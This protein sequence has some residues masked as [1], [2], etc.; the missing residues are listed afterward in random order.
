MLN[1]RNIP[2][3]LFPWRTGSSQS[4]GLCE[5]LLARSR[6]CRH[7]DP[8]QMLLLAERA[9]AVALELDP[10][11]YG[12]ELVADMRARSLAELSNA[13]RVADDLEAAERAM[14]RAVEWSSQGT[15]DPLLL[16]R[17]MDLTASLRGAQ[18]RFPEALV[19]LQA[20][21]TLYER[22]GDRHSAGRALISKGLFTGYNNDPERAIEL[23]SA[24]ISM[25]QPAA[26]PKLVLSALHNLIGFMA[27]CGRFRQAQRLL[28]RCRDAY[29]A[30]GDRLS[31]LRL[32]WLEGRI[33][34]GLR[35]L[36]RAEK[37]LVQARHEFEQAGLINQAALISL[38]LAAVWLLQGKNGHTRR[39]IEE[40]V[41]VFRAQRIAR[42]VLAALILLKESFENAQSSPYE[43]L[44]A[45]TGYLKRFEARPLSSSYRPYRRYRS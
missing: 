24:G 38:D 23:L 36:R 8:E 6:A 13:Y 31:L 9:A 26:D 18:R 21:Y 7:N 2:E 44:R 45:I 42:E 41:A 4:W 20:V 17:I 5:S 30:A 29:F 25:I 10:M 12:R 34:F 37:S 28:R 16:A 15:Q 22:H 3:G 39:L 43:L 1:D 11:E 33:A 35:Q 40:M 14:R 32:C 19:L 27:D